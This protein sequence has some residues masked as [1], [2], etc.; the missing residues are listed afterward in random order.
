MRDTSSTLSM[1]PA[2]LIFLMSLLLLVGEKCLI[3]GPHGGLVHHCRPRQYFC[4]H[5]TGDWNIVLVN[6][7]NFLFPFLN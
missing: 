4:V 1:N 3:G 7:H 6:E 2:I 5:F